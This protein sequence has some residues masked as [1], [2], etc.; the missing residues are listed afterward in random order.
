MKIILLSLL[1]LC[2]A[3]VFSQNEDRVILQQQLLLSREKQASIARQQA[4]KLQFEKQE[5]Q[6][7]EQEKL[8]LQLRVRQKESELQEEYSNAQASELQARYQTALR[9]KRILRQETD[10]RQSRRWIY[11]LI[12]VSILIFVVSIVIYLSHRK[13]RRLNQLITAQHEELQQVSHVKDRL[14]A[15]VGHDMRSPLNMLLGL[16][17]ILQNEKIP[18]AKMEAYM[19]QLEST[20]THT[21]SL[22]DNLLH[23]AASQMQGYKPH[24]Q[25]VNIAEITSDAVLL[26]KARAADKGITLHQKVSPE[27]LVK[28]DP[29]MLTLIIRNLVSNAVKF[30]S[31]GSD[32]T[33]CSAEENNHTIISVTDNG[34]GMSNALLSHFNS[35]SL[36]GL[37]S[38]RGTDK[39]KG[40]GLGLLLCKTFT[41]LMNGRIFA[42]PNPQGTGTIFKIILPHA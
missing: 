11:Y 6:L 34:T 21:S 2:P 4:E 8:L 41:R 36:S 33:V 22:M 25:S 23:W 3:F 27:L 35:T 28:C 9:D 31:A 1:F 26:Q 37:E 7:A 10:I 15:I 17:Q 29:D 16:S 38:T 30:S 24:V 18:K 14:L 5:K 32:I 19:Q 40:T 13:A 42:L 39:E 12:S 20:L